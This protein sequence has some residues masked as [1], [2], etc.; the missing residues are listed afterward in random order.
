MPTIK[1]L[2]AERA[3]ILEEIQSK[4]KANTNSSSSLQD[5]LSAAEE[6]VPDSILN[7]SPVNASSARSALTQPN[8]DL[9]ANLAAANEAMNFSVNSADEF[10]D[11]YVDLNSSSQATN[12]QS[13][14]E[15]KQGSGSAANSEFQKALQESRPSPD[16]RSDRSTMNNSTT[17]SQPPVKDNRMAFIGVVL[18]L[19][20][21]VTTLVILF[22]SYNSLEQKYNEA[23]QLRNDTQ[24][25]VFA[26]QEEVTKLKDFAAIGENADQKFSAID[27]Q[28]QQMNTMMQ[29]LQQRLNEKSTGGEISIQSEGTIAAIDAMLDKKLTIFSE[30]L[31]SQ[32]EQKIDL[33]LAAIIQRIE[34]AEANNKITGEANPK[35]KT[36]V[37]IN[38]EL[39]EE[40]SMAPVA[41]PSTPQA[42]VIETLTPQKPKVDNAITQPEPI[43]NQIEKP[44]FKL[45]ASSKQPK[46]IK[47]PDVDENTPTEIKWLLGEPSMHY[48]LQ[49]ASMPNRESL[50]K[51]KKN[52]RLVEAKI[53]PQVYKGKTNYILVTD[54]FISRTEANKQSQAIKKQTG[55]A[56]WVRKIS[57]IVQKLD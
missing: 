30:R 55:I 57:T 48:T 25:Q 34:K 21:F 9:Q 51:M 39:D 56:P 38:K 42:P 45:E 49:L 44:I 26:L 29:S 36:P 3:K 22:F 19:L 40:I 6:L 4:A 27:Q 23:V 14:S 1:E 52:M 31:S 35:F 12:P 13:N 37:S 18:M 33:K 46:I 11:D 17:S 15:T 54:S 28:L 20:M 16:L 50:E 8:S 43:V 41:E 2:E 10:D 5:F 47:T 24:E 7:E 53:I 32:I